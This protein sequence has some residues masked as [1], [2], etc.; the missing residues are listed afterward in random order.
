M[1][2]SLFNMFGSFISLFRINNRKLSAAN[3]CMIYIYIYINFLTIILN[4][5]KSTNVHIKLSMK[6]EPLTVNNKPNMNKY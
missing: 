2:I 3:G 6:I 4:T 5:N 1:P